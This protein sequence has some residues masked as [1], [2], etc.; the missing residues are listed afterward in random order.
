MIRSLVGNPAVI[1][2]L[3][4]GLAA[5]SHLN[6]QYR[7]DRQSVK[8]MGLGKLKGKLK[9]FG[10]DAH[11]WRTKLQKRLLFL[12]ASIAYTMAPVIEPATLTLTL[13]NE[14]ALEMAI[15]TPYEQAIQTAMQALDDTSRNLFE[16]LLK[17]H[18]K[19]VGWLEQQLTLVDGLA[20][21][22]GESRYIAEK[23]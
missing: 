21:D 7:S 16:H 23:I 22:S 15:V 20:T 18:Q 4:V 8:F 9:Q 1:K 3:Q 13:E 2:A 17:W 12:G 5:E 14:L 10:G 19:H 11:K 6:E